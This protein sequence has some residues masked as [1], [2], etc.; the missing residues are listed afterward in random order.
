VDLDPDGSHESTVDLTVS[1]GSEPH[2]DSYPAD[3]QRISDVERGRIVDAVLPMPPGRSLTAG[4]SIVFALAY[5]PAGQEASY[6]IGGDSICVLLTDVTDLETIDPDT[7]EALF[8]LSWKPL[9]QGEP[10]DQKAEGI[11]KSRG[12]HRRR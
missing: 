9:G 11:A 3:E 8:R 12:R 1:L 10:R 2:M 4:D 7:G 6:V 5:S